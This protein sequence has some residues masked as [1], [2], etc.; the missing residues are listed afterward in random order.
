MIAAARELLGTHFEMGGRLLDPGDGIDCQGVLFYA[1]E[2]ISHCGWKS[3][4]VMPT[5]S[6]AWKELG[7]AVPNFSPI[8]TKDLDPLKLLPGDIVLLV[9]F[10][11]NSAEPAIGKLDHKPVWVWHTGI[12]VGRGNWINADW[13]VEEGPLLDYLELYKDS[14]AGV[15]ITRMKYGPKPKKCK[16]DKKIQR[17]TKKI[18]NKSGVEY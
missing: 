4:S 8:A 14:F 13:T 16:K 5:K 7:A 10:E 11:E 6:V 15:F 1:A 2:R 9:G 17:Q 18:P 12:Y 3:Y